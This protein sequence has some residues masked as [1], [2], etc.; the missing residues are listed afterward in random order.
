MST[1]KINKTVDTSK[2][3]EKPDQKKVEKKKTKRK[4]LVQGV[5]KKKPKGKNAHTKHT[6][7]ATND[8]HKLTPN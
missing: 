1:E 7:Y 8:G 4:P 6:N 2:A 3:Q 5:K